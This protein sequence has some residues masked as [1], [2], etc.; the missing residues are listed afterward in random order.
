VTAPDDD[1]IRMVDDY[2]RMPVRMVACPSVGE[3]LGWSGCR[4]TTTLNFVSGLRGWVVSSLTRH[5]GPQ[6]GVGTAIVRCSE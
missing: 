2:S 4:A 3:P 6:L 1:Y 5:V